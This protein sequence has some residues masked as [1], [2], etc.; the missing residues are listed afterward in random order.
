MM[1]K[2]HLITFYNILKYKVNM[3]NVTL[4]TCAHTH[5]RQYVHKS[6][7]FIPVTSCSSGSIL[8]TFYDLL[9]RTKVFWAAFFFLQFGYVFFCWKNIGAKDARKMLVKLTLVVYCR[10]NSAQVQKKRM[11]ELIFFR[12]KMLYA[13]NYNFFLFT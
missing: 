7:I 12:A 6:Q 3:H 9:F 11:Y 10:N 13:Q 5:K 2:H 8:P 4:V 1:Q